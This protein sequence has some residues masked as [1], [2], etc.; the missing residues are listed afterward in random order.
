MWLADEGKSTISRNMV[1]DEST[2]YMK[3]KGKEVDCVP[4]SKRVIFRA[5][6]I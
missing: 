4:K 1:F 5:D 3:S 2:L 6:L